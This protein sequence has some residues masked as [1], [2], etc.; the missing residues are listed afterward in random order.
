KPADRFGHAQSAVEPDLLTRLVL[1][2]EVSVDADIAVPFVRHVNVEEHRVHRA[3]EHA[4][5]ALDAHIGVD[6]VLGRIRSGVDARCGADV[7]ARAV[8]LT[9]AR[10]GDDVGHGALSC[11]SGSSGRSVK[12]SSAT[13]TSRPKRGVTNRPSAFRLPS[14]AAAANRSPR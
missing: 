12:M 3:D 5:L 4:L 7:D 13:C 1:A 11:P 10:L 9:D 14:P 8:P 6:I 2:K